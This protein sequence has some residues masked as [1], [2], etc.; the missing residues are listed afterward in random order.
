MISA[1]HRQENLYS[2]LRIC[3][4]FAAFIAF[5]IG[6]VTYNEVNTTS[7]SHAQNEEYYREETNA[8]GEITKER[9]V[10]TSTTDNL[11]YALLSLTIILGKFKICHDLS[12]A[13]ASIIAHYALKLRLMKMQFRL[14]NKDTLCSSKLIY[15][16]ILELV[17]CSLI[18]PPGFDFT[19]SGKMLGGTY[20]Y[21]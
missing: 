3:D 15:K 5:V 20:T 6:I 21:S 16:L 13:D 12:S 8:D 7:I 9:N 10:S 11:R 4:T 14:N 18:S 1:A 17:I 19:F 2:W